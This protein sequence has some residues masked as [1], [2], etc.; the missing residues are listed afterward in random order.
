[1]PKNSGGITPTIVKAVPLSR[2]FLPTDLRIAVQF[3]FPIAIADHGGGR[4]CGR[5]VVVCKHA[6]LHRI[7]AENSKVVS[8][9]QMARSSLR[10]SPMARLFVSR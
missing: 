9:N 3:L 6:S 10:A 8:G 1:M 5:V 2:M 7:D 4:S